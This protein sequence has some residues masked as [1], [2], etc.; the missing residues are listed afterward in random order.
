MIMT[1]LHLQMHLQQTANHRILTRLSSTAR[2]Q[3]T[4]AIARQI[5]TSFIHALT[6]HHSPSNAADVSLS[7]A[8]HQHHVYLT[9]LRKHIPT[10]CLPP[11][12]CHPDCVFVEDTVV[13]VEDT[14][15][16][17]RSGHESR[18]GEV[19]T[20]RDVLCQLGMKVMDMGD[21]AD[22]DVAYCDGGDVM[23]TGRHL[24]VGL[25]GRTNDKGFQFLQRVFGEKVEVV[26]V[27]PV[28]QG[29]DVLHLKSA[30][31]YSF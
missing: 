20:I 27:P 28:I 30:G 12:E 22:D 17:C 29:R 10:L 8:R 5:P 11:L 6:S 24:F 21:D 19:D 15:V 16:I 1:L 14:A 4:L 26:A 13:A 18:R 2:S 9:E 7:I 31:E 3:S 23:Y 25:S